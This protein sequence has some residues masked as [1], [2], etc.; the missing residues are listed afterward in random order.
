MILGPFFPVRD[1]MG[2]RAIFHIGTG[3]GSKIFLAT[4][5]ASSKTFAVKHVTREN[6]EDD[7]FVEQV[8]IEFKVARVDDPDN[9]VRWCD[10]I[11][12]PQQDIHRDHLV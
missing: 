3:A 9:D 6:A 12:A 5:L 10:I 7:K 2:A 11:A 1:K 8:E 4:E